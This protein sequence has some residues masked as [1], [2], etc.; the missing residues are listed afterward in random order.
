MFQAAPRLTK[1][2]ACVPVYI[3]ADS[4]FTFYLSKGGKTNGMPDVKK[5]LGENPNVHLRNKDG[6]KAR[7]LEK[8]M[9]QVWKDLG[10][11]WG[12]VILMYQFHDLFNKTVALKGNAT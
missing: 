7:D 6:G 12:H 11:N 8:L 4:S 3:V 1:Y 2:L 10:N 9:E 5:C